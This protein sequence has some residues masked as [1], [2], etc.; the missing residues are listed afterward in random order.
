MYMRRTEDTDSTAC[1]QLATLSPQSLACARL[2]L[3]L[4]GKKIVTI[5]ISSNDAY[6]NKKINDTSGFPGW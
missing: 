3:C 2:P 4:H 1:N 6:C 5:R